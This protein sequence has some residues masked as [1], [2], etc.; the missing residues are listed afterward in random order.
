MIVIRAA[1][2]RQLANEPARRK[3]GQ[4]QTLAAQ[5]RL[6]RVAELSGEVREPDLVAPR[7]LDQGEKHL[8]PQDPLQLLRREAEDRQEAAAELALAEEHLAP[9]RR[10]RAHTPRLQPFASLGGEPRLHPRVDP[11]PKYAS[12][13]S[14]NSGRRGCLCRPLRKARTFLAP[15]ALQWDV[16]VSQLSRLSSQDGR[17]GARAKARAD[18]RPPGHRGRSSRPRQRTDETALAA[19]WLAHELRGAV[20]NDELRPPCDIRRRPQDPETGH[21]P[22]ETTRRRKLAICWTVVHY[23]T[24]I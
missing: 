20:R 12:E 23:W 18:K 16:D 3:T 13:N 5:M 1:A 2:L 6:V 11:G 14:E 22:L 8:E 24:I 7:S 15:T 9:D 21:L 19:A 4:P 17:R 10:R